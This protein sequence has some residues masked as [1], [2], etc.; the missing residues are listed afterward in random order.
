MLW[1]QNITN[2]DLHRKLMIKSKSHL[3]GLYQF[4]LIDTEKLND[5][6]SNSNKVTSKYLSAELLSLSEKI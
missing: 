5:L 1:K 2:K 4:F 6:M 3:E